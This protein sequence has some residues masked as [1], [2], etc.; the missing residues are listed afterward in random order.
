MP[1]GDRTGP[2]G[3]GPKTG[4][5]MGYCMDGGL[6]NSVVPIYKG[7]GLIGSIGGGLLGGL[8]TLLTGGLAAPLLP[9]FIGLG[10]SL[11]GK[12]G[13]GIDDLIPD[14]NQLQADPVEALPPPRPVS[15]RTFS[16]GAIAPNIP[17]FQGGGI[18]Q[19]PKGNDMREL[20][21]IDKMLI[22][23]DGPVHEE[24]GIDVADSEVEGGETLFRFKD[25]DGNIARFIFSNS[26]MV[27]GKKITFADLSKEINNKTSKRPDSDKIANKTKEKKLKDLMLQQ[28]GLNTDKDMVKNKKL[29]G[30]GGLQMGNAIQDI[31][32]NMNVGGG[33]GLNTNN[34]PFFGAMPQQGGGGS[35]FFGGL[36]NSLAGMGTSMIGSLP[37]LLGA[38]GPLA[39]L[40]LANR[41]AEQV[42]FER[43]Q[44]PGAP[45]FVDPSQAVRGVGETFGGVNQAIRSAASR[46]G[47]YI[48][49]RIASGA[50][51]AG[52]KSDILGRAQNV[53]AQIANRR[54]ELL[55][56]ARARN[57]MIGRS[58]ALTN[59]ASRGAREGA[60]IDAISS[61]GNIGGQYFRDVGQQ[62]AQNRQNELLKMLLNSAFGN[63]G[64]GG[65]G[66]SLLGG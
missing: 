51:E 43:I 8:A 33:Y 58:E 55:Q 20:Q 24:G 34:Y 17:T 30:G 32:G 49:S 25:M 28:E 14:R 9:A 53:N 18:L 42:A 38:A 4:R 56:Q 44:A 26:K 19:P 6:L 50:K 23:L 5:Q 22:E 36:G 7:G 3:E 21:S 66:F 60:R 35:G 40:R 64:Y 52:A 39:Q 65:G 13:Q 10:S 48:T 37:G 2:R 59:L 12:I 11:G 31:F 46:P 41:P 29:Q 27:P 63:I 47:Q 15:T 54:A 62:Q 16:G 61:L 45:Q 1:R 57:A